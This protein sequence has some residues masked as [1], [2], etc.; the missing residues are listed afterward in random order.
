MKPVQPDI[1]SGGQAAS[2]LIVDDTPANLQVLAGMLKDRGYRVRPVPSGKLALQAA[3]RD[4][5][6]LI[7]LDINMPDMNGYE[8]CERLKADE[9]LKGIPI[10]FISALTEPLDKVKAFSTGGVDYLT[11]PFHMEELHARV[12]THLKLR[13]LRRELENTNRRLE[14]INDRMSRDLEAAAKIQKTFLPGIA[15]DIP[16]TEFAWV[17]RPCDE[18]A[19]DALNIIPL[20]R[21]RV[22]LYILDVSGHGVASA[23]LSVSLSR[24]LSAPSDPSSILIRDRD[25]L[26][27]PNLIPPAEVANRLNQLFPFNIATG[28]FATLIYGVL[29]VSSG[30]FCHVCAGHAGPLHLPVAG[31]A[32]ILENPGFPIGVADE[33][34]VER[35]FHLAPGDRFYLYSDGLTDA[36]SPAGENF[37]DARLLAAIERGRAKPPREGID[38][39]LNEIGQWQEGG[40]PQDDISLVA[41]EVSDAAVRHT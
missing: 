17:Y 1:G 41:V 14:S 34:Y 21:G 9:R 18:L 20:G 27:S 29:D 3:Q 4:P 8:V 36:M 38:M 19:G 12:E 23:L 31:P 39:L 7:L 10:I 30:N 22:G 35:S 25:V 32:V 2:I 15:P 5:P 13:Q 33:V 26:H 37:G 16:G 6:D 24:L 40:K 11:K 28:Q